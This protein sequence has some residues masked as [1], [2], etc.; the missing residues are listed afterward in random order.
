MPEHRA[1]TVLF[2]IITDELT[3]PAKVWSNLITGKLINTPPIEV[4]ALWDTGAVVT[5]IK[6][7][8]Q[9]QLNLRLLN[10]QTL[11]EGVGGEVNAYVTLV[12]IQLMC[13]VEIADCP[14]HVIL[15]DSRG[16][17]EEYACSTV[18]IF[19]STF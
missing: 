12:N 6:P 14:V 17:G 4:T 15:C 18:I 7:R 5:C 19:I 1:F 11:L 13:D 10:T 8:L 9:K 2:D 3:S 16:E